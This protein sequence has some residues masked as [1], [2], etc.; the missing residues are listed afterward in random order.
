V[1]FEAHFTY[2]K[3][4]RCQYLKIYH[5]LYNI[6]IQLQRSGVICEQL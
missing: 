4:F 2:Y 3:R 6:R 5:N 1:T